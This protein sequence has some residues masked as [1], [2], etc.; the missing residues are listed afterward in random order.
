MDATS[1]TLY[2]LVIRI[3][4]DMG[5]FAVV[6]VAALGAIHCE[7]RQSCVLT[8]YDEFNSI[9]P[10]VIIWIGHFEFM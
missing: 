7:Y 8:M 9:K 5:S 10:Y 1:Y 2:G 4:D 6:C 3:A